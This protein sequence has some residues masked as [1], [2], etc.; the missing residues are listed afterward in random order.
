MALV[1]KPNSA[2]ISSI[3]NK[4][5]PL[6]KATLCSFSFIIWSI[7]KL[8]TILLASLKCCEDQRRLKY[9]SVLKFISAKQTCRET[10]AGLESEW[11]Q[12]SIPQRVCDLCLQMSAINMI[13]KQ[14]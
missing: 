6:E 14:G 12:P 8:I 10:L 4:T 1:R 9:D 13:A 3:F 5:C 7:R 11:I 2:I